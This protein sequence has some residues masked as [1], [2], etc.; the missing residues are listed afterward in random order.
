MEKIE[1]AI[2][3]T[4]GIGGN[5]AL[6]RKRICDGFEFLGLYLDGN[7]NAQVELTAYEAPQIRQA[8]SKIRV[9]AT[10]ARE[11]RM[12]ARETTRVAKSL[13]DKKHNRA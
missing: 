3:F 11:Q 2:A 9:L 1:G 13:M 7:K 10:Q 12:I 4:G 6:V 5:S 8:N